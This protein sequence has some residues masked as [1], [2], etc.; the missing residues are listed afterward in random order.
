VSH[1]SSC[2]LQSCLATAHLSDSERLSEVMVMV[3]VFSFLV[4]FQGCFGHGEVMHGGV[5][6][7]KS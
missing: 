7:D 1:S 4:L 2:N 6:V 5:S 3:L